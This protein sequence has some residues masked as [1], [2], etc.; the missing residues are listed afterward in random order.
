MTTQEGSAYI[1]SRR[2]GE[3]SV[4]IISEGELTWAPSLLAPEEAWRRAMPE[5]DEAGR[6][7]LGLNVALVQ[8]AGA[9]ILVD[10]GFD[11]PWSAWQQRADRT[12]GGLPRTPGLAAAL[13]QLGV[14]PEEVTHVPITHAHGDHF[15]GVAVEQGDEIAP[16][17]PRARHFVGRPDWAEHPDR[18]DPD[19]E[20]SQR[21]GLIDRLGLL[22]TVDGDRE[23]APG[24]TMLAAAG[25]TPGH[26]VVRVESAGEVWYDLGDLCH[27]ASEVEHLDW[28]SPGRD[29]AAMRA[30]RERIFAAAAREAAV[31]VTAHEPFPPWGRIVPV[32]TG[33][34]WERLT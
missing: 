33:Y 34:R 28:V 20:L 31:V 27:H 19:S 8:T 32:G 10:P 18:L 9:T 1:A 6:V 25:E 23:I 14:S 26:M 2:V 7:R 30:S 11:D 24:V 4:T 13:A 22:Q 29:Q 12:F 21:L 15:A 16:R 17:F 5:A 3:A